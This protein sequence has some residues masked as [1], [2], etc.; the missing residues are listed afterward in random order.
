MHHY[1]I[2]PS[3]E[4]PRCLCSV[5]RTFTIDYVLVLSVATPVLPLRYVNNHTITIL[6]PPWQRST[7]LNTYSAFVIWCTFH[8][9]NIL[10]TRNELFVFQSVPVFAMRKINFNTCKQVFFVSARES[11]K[12]NKKWSR[13]TLVRNILLW[14]FLPSISSSF[15]MTVRVIL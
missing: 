13:T 5:T 3:G 14:L 10:D 7:P 2:S 1:A 11:L 12:M 15:D 9:F 4:W 8:L 6:P